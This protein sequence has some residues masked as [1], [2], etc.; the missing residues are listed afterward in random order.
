MR[1]II[2]TLLLIV[3]M[4]MPMSSVYASEVQGTDFQIPVVTAFKGS[5]QISKA[6]GMQKFTAFNGMKLGNGDI[7]YTGIDSSIEISYGKKTLLIGSKS[8]VIVNEVLQKYNRDISDVSLIEGSIKNKVDVKLSSNSRNQIITANIVAGVRGTEEVVAYSRNIPLVEGSTDNPYSSLFVLEGTVRVASEYTSVKDNG[9]AEEEIFLVTIDGAS[10]VVDKI[11]ANPEEVNN[12][13]TVAVKKSSIVETVAE[14]IDVS[15]LEAIITESE[16]DPGKISPILINANIVLAEKKLEAQNQLIE[17]AEEEK[18]EHQPFIVFGSVLEEVKDSLPPPENSTKLPSMEE[19]V[20]ETTTMQATTTLQTTTTHVE[21]TREVETTTTKAMPTNEAE[22][23]T[24]KA[25]PTKEAETTT[26]KAVPIKEAETT[27]TKAVPT[28]GAKTTTTKAVPTTEEKTTTIQ[29]V[30]TTESETTTTQ[31]ES[32]TEVETTTQEEPTTEEETTTTAPEPISQ[33]T[34]YITD[35]GTITYGDSSFTLSTTGGSGTGIV[36][37]SIL[38]GQSAT[39]TSDG[40]VSIL[41]QGEFTVRAIKAADSEYE[42]TEAVLS[43]SIGKRDLSNIVIGATTNAIYTGVPIIP[44]PN[45]TDMVLGENLI[46]STDFEYVYLNNTNAGTATVTVTAKADGNY[47]GSKPAYFTIDKANQSTLEMN[48]ISNIKYGDSPITLS[49]LGGTGNGDVTYIIDSG[50]QYASVLGDKLSILGAGTV[51]V[52]AVKAGDINHEDATSVAITFAIEKANQE[53]L[54]INDFSIAYGDTPKTLTTTGGTTNGDVTYRVI[55]GPGTIGSDNKLSVTAGGTVVVEATMTG[56]SNY[57]EVV[58]QSKTFTVN[59]ATLKVSAGD[60]SV[61]YGNS[62]TFEAIYTGFVNGDTKDELTGTVSFT[63]TYNSDG[64]SNVGQY[65]ITP[66]NTISSEKYEVVNETST[67]TVTKRPITLVG[68][69]DQTMSILSTEVSLY[70]VVTGE[71]S[72]HPVS[73]T[74]T[75]NNSAVTN[76]NDLLIY[77]PSKGS[78]TGT[79]TVTLSIDSSSN[80]MADSV[81]LSFVIADGVNIPVPVDRSNIYNMQ[82]KSYSNMK[83]EL[84]QNISSLSTWIPIALLDNCEFN[85]KGH[86]IKDM[87]LTTG[88]YYVNSGFVAKTKGT[89]VIKYLGIEDSS[90]ICQMN[91]AESTISIGFIVGYLDDYGT[92]EN[93]YVAGNSIINQKLPEVE[94]SLRVDLSVGLVVGYSRGTIEKCYATG[95]IYTTNGKRVLIAG[96]QGKSESSYSFVNDCIAIEFYFNEYN[97]V[98]R[99]VAAIGCIGASTTVS[100]NYEYG[101]SAARGQAEPG[102]PYEDG[103]PFSAATKYDHFGTRLPLDTVLNESWWTDTLNFSIDDWDFTQPFAPKLKVK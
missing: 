69:V 70:Y 92:V 81:D 90:A 15:I 78:G 25:E 13:Q 10:K 53:I 60:C 63:T 11:A 76:N 86:V 57:N 16:G 17:K 30:T 5:V 19:T 12:V 1:K 77:D 35:P 91:N 71:L 23:T 28:T 101:G 27:T 83:F 64:S 73:V 100:N 87:V 33:E 9:I 62:K 61:V 97:P 68:G 21:P 4:M 40:I 93:C 56:N 79:N 41:S 88:Q 66:S 18:S 7:I 89:T 94:D 3:T 72:S 38:D 46:K 52:Y 26:T 42:E 48:S 37:Y 31:E 20:N 98:S 43:I 102:V 103:S 2:I 29:A 34:L 74:I 95:E 65:D 84:T 32:T 45:I 51:S 99:N 67:L 58:S 55:S 39:V 96:I 80:Y 59:K 6:G 36:T 44:T 85:G 50:S 47:Y 75:S 24:T 8:M 14:N 54:A 49:T 82:G 22:T